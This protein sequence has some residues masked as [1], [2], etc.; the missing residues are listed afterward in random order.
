MDTCA[1]FSSENWSLVLDTLF[2]RH[3]NQSLSIRNKTTIDDD[4]DTTPTTI[5]EITQHVILRGSL[6]PSRTFLGLILK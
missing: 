1:S 5:S 3:A 6:I 4:Y 2:I